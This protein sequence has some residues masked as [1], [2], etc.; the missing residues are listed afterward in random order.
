[1]CGQF[2][3]YTVLD[4]SWGNPAIRRMRNPFNDLR[5]A[6]SFAVLS[7]KMIKNRELSIQKLASSKKEANRYYSFL[8]SK[9]VSVEETI[10]MSCAIRPE[11]VANRD[12]LHIGDTSTYNLSKRKGRIQDMEKLGVLQ[13]G[14][15]PGF[16]LHAGM[17]VDA[18]R[19]TILGL[20]DVQLWNRPKVDAPTIEGQ[21]KKLADKES[22]KWYVGSQNANNALQAAGRVTHLYDS[23]ADSFALMEGIIDEL[24]NDLIIR[25]H[26]NRQVIWKGQQLSLSECL[27]QS[28]ALGRYEIKL[29]ALDHYSWTAGKRIRRKA[30]EAVIELRAV[31]VELLAPA[32]SN[33]KRKLP[34]YMVEARETTADLPKGEQPVIWRLWTTHVVESFD[35][36]KKI[37]DFYNG[38]W[39][40]EQL[41]RTTKKKGFNQEATELETTEAILKQATIVISTACKVLQLVYARDKYQGLPIGDGFNSTQQELLQKLN[42]QLQGNTEKQKN[43][44]PPDQL[45]WAAWVIARLGGWKGYQS[46]KP[47]GPLT[48]KYGVEKFYTLLQGYLLFNSS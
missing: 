37:V 7:E 40:I 12:V 43:P 20:A 24:K 36:A 4:K 22:Y 29:R 28:E 25:A 45:G 42:T 6:N 48:M 11:M 5:Y 23:E 2:R 14:K 17:A 31:K 30:R 39:M 16:F 10:R 15:T 26:H 33:N 19:M 8:K 46:A 38:R 3:P 34:L 32:E 27:D 41:F 9:R 13:D 47:P 1:M 35:Q 18:E 44:F 21:P